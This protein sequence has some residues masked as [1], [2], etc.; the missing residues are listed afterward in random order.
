MKKWS[1]EIERKL[2]QKIVQKVLSD[3]YV[4]EM[5]FII[6]IVKRSIGIIDYSFLSLLQIFNIW[7]RKWK[8]SFSSAIYALFKKKKKKKNSK[9]D[10]FGTCSN[11]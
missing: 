6:N 7:Q 8:E 3:S 2:R 4:M 9:Q 1:E 11:V 5:L 10:K